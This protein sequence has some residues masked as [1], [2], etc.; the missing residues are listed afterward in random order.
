MGAQL[1][2]NKLVKYST[3][4]GGAGAYTAIGGVTSAGFTI[5]GE[6][7]DDNCFVASH[8]GYKSRMQGIADMTLD[9]TMQY[10]SSSDA[11]QAAIIYAK[12]NRTEIWFQYLH[13]GTAG[14]K[15]RGTPGDIKFDGGPNDVEGLSVTI[16]GDGGGSTV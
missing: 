11:G 16:E 9:L 4:S 10:S 14:W 13:N 6:V 7:V 8:D 15:F 2:Y 1:A 3:T 12:S 5:G